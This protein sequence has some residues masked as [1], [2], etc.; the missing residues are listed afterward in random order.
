MRYSAKRGTIRV[1]TACVNQQAE[2]DREDIYTSDDED[3]RKS[4][5]DATLIDKVAGCEEAEG[6]ENDREDEIDCRIEDTES[7]KNHCGKVIP[8]F[9]KTA[10][11]RCM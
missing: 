2:Q 9:R 11:S 1:Y 6:E 8:W 10:C 5:V 3:V 4:M 7:I